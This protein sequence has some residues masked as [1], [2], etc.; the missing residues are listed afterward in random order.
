LYA[1]SLSLIVL[2]IRYPLSVSSQYLGGSPSS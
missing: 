2:S 1:V